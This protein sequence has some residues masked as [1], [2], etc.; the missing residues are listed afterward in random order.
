MLRNYGLGCVAPFPLPFG[1]HLKTGYLKTGATIGELAKNIGIDPA[2]LKTTVD[3]FNSDAARGEDPAFGKGSTAYNRYQ[4]DELIL[5]NPCVAPIVDAPF[6]AVAVEPADL[7]MAAGVL[8]DEDALEI[9]PIQI[10]A[11]ECFMDDQI[12]GGTSNQR[13][14]FCPKP[15]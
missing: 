8:T 3:A 2:V 10:T 9:A 5:P 4:G 15:R 13:A 7:G 12:F 6:Y 14:V 1:R 11:C